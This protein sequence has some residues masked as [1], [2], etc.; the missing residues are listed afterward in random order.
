MSG[1]YDEDIVLWSE[2]QAEL[3]RRVAAGEPVSEAPDWPNIVEEIESVGSEQIH[4]VTSLLRQALIHMLKAEAWPQSRDAPSWRA[5]AIGF[6]AQASD[7]YVASMRQKIDL[8]RLYRQALRAI[9]ETVGGIAPLPIESEM[10]T[11]DELLSDD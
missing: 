9:P 7:R 10:P 2:R 1:L 3:L 11:L 4:A 6:R 5:D 8:A